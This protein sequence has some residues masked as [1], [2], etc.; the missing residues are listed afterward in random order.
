[1]HHRQVAVEHQDVVAVHGKALQRGRSVA[2][3][4]DRERLLPQTLGDSIDEQPFVLDDE[5]PHLALL[6]PAG[7]QVRS[8]LDQLA[9][10]LR[11][12]LDR[13]AMLSGPR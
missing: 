2:G 5:H 4:V 12:P 13:L 8:P 11:S 6:P 9:M 7:A 10:Q 3:D 1:V